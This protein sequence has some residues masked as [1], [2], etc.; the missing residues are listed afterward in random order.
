MDA[1][2]VRKELDEIE[3]LAKKYQNRLFHPLFFAQM[4]KKFQGNFDKV[5]GILT[6]HAV[7][8]YEFQP[9]GR[10]V[11]I[12]K[13]KQRDYLILPDA[14]YCHCTNF[15]M[16]ILSGKGRVC[17]HLAAQ[18]ISATLNMY[19]LVMERDELFPSLME[20]WTYNEVEQCA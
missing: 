14:P 20:E 5:A 6:D 9:S 1:S 2:E 11:W 8:K 10:T 17:G 18:R 7:L 12:V 16:H 15:Y 4:N 3:A 19:Q 13:G